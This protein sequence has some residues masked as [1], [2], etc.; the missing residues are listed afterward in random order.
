MRATNAPFQPQKLGGISVANQDQML[1]QNA[2][3]SG[4]IIPS[5]SAYADI[6]SEVK[7]L[8]PEDILPIGDGHFCVSGVF[9]SNHEVA[10]KRIE[11]KA[12]CFVN[13]AVYSR[14][15]EK[16]QFIT[17]WKAFSLRFANKVA[18]ENSLRLLEKL[19]QGAG[20]PDGKGAMHLTWF[21]DKTFASEEC[22]TV[23]NELRAA[24]EGRATLT[25]RIPLNAESRKAKLHGTTS[26][27]D[28]RDG[29]DEALAALA[30]GK[31]KAKTISDDIVPPAAS[32]EDGWD[33]LK[34]RLANEKSM[35]DFKSDI[36]LDKVQVNL[37]QY[38]GFFNPIPTELYDLSV[39]QAFG[40]ANNGGKPFI[41]ADKNSGP[42]MTGPMGV[43]SWVVK[44]KKKKDAARELDSTVPFEG[45]QRSAEHS[46]GGS[47]LKFDLDDITDTDL[48]MARDRIKASGL[49]AMVFTTHSHRAPN[50]GNRYRVV[51]ILDRQASV[52]EFQRASEYLGR[53][54]F[55]RT[56]DKSEHDPYQQAGIW[57]AHP[58]RVDLA[59]CESFEGALVSRDKVLAQAPAKAPEKPT[60]T[61]SHGGGVDA[62]TAS[63]MRASSESKDP[64]PVWDEKCYATC[65][66]ALTHPKIRD[67]ASP[68]WNETQGQ[69]LSALKKS[70]ELTPYEYQRQAEERC[71]AL[72]VAY[73]LNN[74]RGYNR[75]HAESD[76]DEGKFGGFSRSPFYVVEI[77]QKL[78][79]DCSH[80]TGKSKTAASADTVKGDVKLIRASEIKAEPIRWLWEGQLAKGKIHILGGKPGTSKTTMAMNLSAIIS[81]GGKLPDGRRCD[82]GNVL[83]WSGEDDPKDTLVPRLIANGADME[84]VFFVDATLDAS[85]KMLP[86]DPARDILRL[87]ERAKKLGDVSLV[88]VDPIVSAVAGD[89]NSNSEVRRD[90]QPLVDLAENL[91]CA[92]LGITHFTKGSG[93]QAAV[94]RITGSLAFGAVARIIHVCFRPKDKSEGE[95]AFMRG[96]SNI[97]AV[98]GGFLYDIEQMLLPG[99]LI[100]ASRIQ[101]RGS[102]SGLAEDALAKAEADEKDKPA[103]EIAKEFLNDRLSNGPMQFGDLVVE[104][105]A[106]GVSESTLQ[107]ASR[108]LEVQR[109]KWGFGKSSVTWWNLLAVAWPSDWEDRKQD[110]LAK[111]A[112]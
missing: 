111:K 34:E 49:R 75:N 48:A 25:P 42:Y 12:N 11:T 76:W 68:D 74:H 98:G 69:V 15:E 92:V 93:G 112:A 31:P 81:S 79:F 13:G 20:I 16:P 104:A 5:A 102:I 45:V 54:L 109:T 52:G 17:H 96:K 82:A 59:T 103:L 71:K 55:G 46:T 97:S 10:L 63:L 57:M 89:G 28:I 105:K 33:T 87:E 32:E 7:N 47:M 72:Y 21:F 3:E 35:R 64:L 4:D 85:G 110:W 56:Y 90:L 24:F 40:I 50:K 22:E 44:T 8:K 2:P 43:A 27:A 14:K 60:K 91:D 61:R 83:V 94:D 86:F 107:R 106:E 101:W 1:S 37:C 23:L 62:L 70:V 30:G 88:I 84:R 66:E 29:L 51:M 67:V 9:F 38:D 18:F 19:P 41:T 53:E 39:D 99:T 108:E 58:D 36:S 6:Q 80:I 73:A 65:I 77:A 95:F 100:E 78:G 26:I